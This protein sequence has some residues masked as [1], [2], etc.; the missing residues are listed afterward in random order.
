MYYKLAATPLE[1]IKVR[2]GK[3]KQLKTITGPV[4]I[5]PEEQSPIVLVVTEILR[6]RQTD[7]QTDGQTDRRT[8]RQTD[9]QTDR[10]TYIV[11]LCILDKLGQ[12]KVQ[13]LDMYLFF[14]IFA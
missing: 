14:V 8:D 9:G 12:I 6:F 5:F 11:L 3:R 4:G 2:G 1:E 10:Q 13:V 7:G